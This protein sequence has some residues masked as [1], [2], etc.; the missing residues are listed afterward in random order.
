[1]YQALQQWQD[2]LCGALPSGRGQAEYF[3]RWNVRQEDYSGTCRLAGSYASCDFDFGVSTISIPGRL[4]RSMTNIWAPSI[5]LPLLMTTDDLLRL[6]TTKPFE[7]G[8]LIFLLSSSILQSLTCIQCLLSPFIQ[9]VCSHFLV[10]SLIFD[11]RGFRK[12]FRSAI[13]R[14]SNSR[15]QH[16]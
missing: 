1:M 14:Q 7:H 13:T 12:I 10:V 4:P 3:P 16:R 5:P 15:V 11:T 6:P 8:T 9:T 2:S